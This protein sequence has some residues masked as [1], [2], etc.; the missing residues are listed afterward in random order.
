MG[1]PNQEALRTRTSPPKTRTPLHPNLRS[2]PALARL[3]GR[4]SCRPCTPHL[5]PRVHARVARQEEHGLGE[6][7]PVRQQV[8]QHGVRLAP[9]V[10]QRAHVCHAPAGAGLDRSDLRAPE[11]GSA[12]GVGRAAWWERRG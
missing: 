11:C 5:P 12:A 9:D 1:I 8:V 2:A 7:T 4:L 6:R 3:P 10:L